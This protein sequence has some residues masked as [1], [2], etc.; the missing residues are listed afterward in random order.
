MRALI[1][2]TTDTRT[3]LFTVIC[4]TD[5]GD[6]D[7]VQFEFTEWYPSAQYPTMLLGG[8]LLSGS[9]V[10]V[11]LFEWTPLLMWVMKVAESTRDVSLGDNT[12]HY[13]PCEHLAI[14]IIHVTDSERA[15]RCIVQQAPHLRLNGTCYV[16]TP[17]HGT[18]WFAHCATSSPAS[19]ESFPGC[20]LTLNQHL[21]AQ[22]SLKVN[23]A[24]WRA[25]CLSA[26]YA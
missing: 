24:Q 7:I 18:P 17:H 13:C 19:L 6:S 11:M 16:Q 5:Y 8:C 14:A 15:A 1:L 25:T 4:V 12:S 21:D 26:P 3:L 23:I 10:N 22:S 2:F 9:D 20:M